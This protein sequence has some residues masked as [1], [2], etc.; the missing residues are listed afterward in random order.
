MARRLDST[1]P[2][3]RNVTFNANRDETRHFA[4]DYTTRSNPMS[5]LVWWIAGIISAILAL[6]LLMRAFGANPEAGFTEFVYN[7]A[8]PFRAPFRNSFDVINIEG[9]GVWE[10]S[11]VLAIAVYLLAA[12]LISALFSMTS[13][14]ALR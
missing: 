10:W 3:E 13:R 9:A 8:E 12:A 6:R 14:Q 7:L 4:D 2:N 5:R 1:G 11:T